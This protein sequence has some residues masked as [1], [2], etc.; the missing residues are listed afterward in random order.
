MERDLGG[1]GIEETVVVKVLSFKGW[2]HERRTKHKEWL[3]LLVVI[4]VVVLFVC[5]CL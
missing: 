2:E 1:K 4:I 5:H 3:K